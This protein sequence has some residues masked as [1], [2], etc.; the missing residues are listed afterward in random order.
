MSL[1]FLSGQLPIF[2][3]MADTSTLGYDFCVL[4]RFSFV[5]T[6]V[7]TRVADPVHFRPDP[8]PENQNS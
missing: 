4:V 3:G 5:F 8:D 7:P 2:W 1:N 6:T